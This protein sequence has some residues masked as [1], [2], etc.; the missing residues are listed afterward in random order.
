M[1]KKGIKALV[2]V[3]LLTIFT[4]SAV[5][6]AK[7][8]VK[9]TE[10]YLTLEQD[11]LYPANMVE[12][13]K[14]PVVFMAHNG[15]ADKSAW[16]DFPEDIADAGF[17]TVNI[18]WNAW[19]A[20]NVESAIN[21]TLEKYADVIDKDRVVFL[22][23]CHGGKDF[24]DILVKENKPYTV[25]TAV[26]LSVSEIDDAVKNSQKEG[27]VPMLVYYSKNDQYGLT[28][29][30]KQFA[31]EIVT[32]PCKIKPQEDPAHGNEMVTNSSNKDVVRKGIIGWMKQ[33]TK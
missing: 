17:F 29:I 30:S 26:L 19:D 33:Y 22:G 4:G 28:D 8:V 10:P 6:A 3:L 20:S 1:K 16:G 32:K 21:Y 7:C 25:K 23:G 24:L 18:T 14:Y 31:E 13:Q 5:Y 9:K 12:G 27:H 11:V 15:Y 2:I